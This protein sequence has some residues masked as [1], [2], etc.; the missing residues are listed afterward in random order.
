M[1]YK[2]YNLS[3]QLKPLKTNTP[4]IAAIRLSPK[5]KTIISVNT[6]S[7]DSTHITS[8]LRKSPYLYNT[9]Y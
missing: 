6:D 4:T 9:T 5:N 1:G 2:F 8:N 7:A 3:H